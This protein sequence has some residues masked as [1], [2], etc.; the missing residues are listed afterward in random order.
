MDLL[1]AL[2]S[3]CQPYTLLIC[4]IG[5]VLGTLVGVLPG[6]GPSTAA[7]LITSLFANTLSVEHAVIL[8]TSIMYGSQYGGST[9]AVLFGIPGESS[10]AITML[11]GKPLVNNGKV[12]LTLFTCAF[13]S[14]I[15]SIISILFIIL[16]FDL[17]SYI[18]LYFSSL[19][20]T[21]ILLCSLIV[22]IY[23]EREHL[24]NTILMVLFGIFLSC[25]GTSNGIDRFTFIIPELNGGID[26]S[27]LAICLFGISDIIH[28]YL[29]KTVVEVNPLNNQATPF[30]FSE[31]K[32]IINPSVRGSLIGLLGIIPGLGYGTLA[33]IS[34]QFEQ[35]LD[36]TKKFGTGMIEGVA[37]PEAANNSAAQTA[38][39]P[40]LT[41]GIPTGSVTS[42]IVAVLLLNGIQVGPN[43][44]TQ[45]AGLF[46][47]I[48]GSMVV[49]N[50]MLFILNYPL[51]KIWISLF[52]INPHIFNTLIL[53]LCFFSIYAMYS[54]YIDMIV[55]ILLSIL[56]VAFRL[57][58]YDMHLIFIGFIYGKLLEDHF[59]RAV[60]LF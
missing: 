33:I 54:T 17:M 44:A 11:D 58:N 60:L 29:S 40:L 34:Y 5:A 51:I 7:A 20:Y 10:S 39:V 24:K 48:M 8:L 14:F 27:I 45:N 4:F 31:F 6:F 12:K 35:L 53:L 46:W 56:F 1:N 16:S 30:S 19:H 49:I 15:G 52:K 32:S 55:I 37:A 41:L 50:V 57:K 59:I 22:V 3:V 47:V 38:F 18:P 25:I 36:K 26:L 9:G 43:F 13:A 28:K 2:I 42:L 23:M 21:I